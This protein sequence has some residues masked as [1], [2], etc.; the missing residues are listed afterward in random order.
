MFDF[1]F[2]LLNTKGM[3]KILVIVVLIVL[4]IFVFGLVSKGGFGPPPGFFAKQPPCPDPLVLQT[5]VD[6]SKV[7]SVL[8]PGQERGGNFKPHGG[9]RF[10]NS[11]PDE[12]EIVAP[13][14][15]KLR[16][17]QAYTEQGEIQY[18][19]D[20]ENPCGIVYRF[21]HIALFSSKFKELTQSLPVISEEDWK[22][23]KGVHQ[24]RPGSF[25]ISVQ[26]GELI[27]TS[28]GFKKTNNVFVDFGVYDLRG[29]N[30]YQ[31]PRPYAVC[32]FDLLT[33]E[34]TVTVKSFPSGDSQNG[35]KS[36]YCK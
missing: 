30:L 1:F 29:K 3:R 4:G 22:S 20:F 2:I 7:T 25:D 26:K 35:K 13:L 15:G 12:I 11:K 14:E 34:D 8:Y 32:W 24:Q 18:L 31:N 21:D 28:V 16:E 19:V 10:D 6:L 36:A 33:A 17:A 5:P 27:A 9:F 23:G